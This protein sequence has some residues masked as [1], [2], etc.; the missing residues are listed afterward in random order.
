MRLIISLQGG[1]QKHENQT[2]QEAH[3]RVQSNAEP[4]GS[5]AVEEEI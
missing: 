5:G 1:E 2:E 4:G 3:D